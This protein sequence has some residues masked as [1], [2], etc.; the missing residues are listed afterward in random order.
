MTLWLSIALGFVSGLVIVAAA[1]VWA[2]APYLKARP[3][4][5]AWPNP[6]EA[7]QDWSNWQGQTLG[8]NPPPGEG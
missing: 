7:P 1:L 3:P 2:L 4:K 5:P 6:R 8:M